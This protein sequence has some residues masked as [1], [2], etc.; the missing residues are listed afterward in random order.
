MHDD[1]T[2]PEGSM[3]VAVTLKSRIKSRSASSGGNSKVVVTTTAMHVR[4]AKAL[5]YGIMHKVYCSLADL[6][7]AG[8]YCISRQFRCDAKV[9]ER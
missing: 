7:I 5:F 3:G 8:I 9:K 1:V 2:R 6:L 4:A